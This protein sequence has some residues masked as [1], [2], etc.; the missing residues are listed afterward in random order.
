[1]KRCELKLEEINRLETT[2]VAPSE[3]LN[4]MLEL[5]GTAPLK[6]G[7]KLAEL[8]RRPQIE[9]KDLEQF[10]K[11]RPALSDDVIEKVEI[12]IKYK[13]YIQKQLAAI[14]EMKRLEE[15]I[16]PKDFDY[17]SISGLRKEAVEKLSKIRPESVG[18][19]SRISGVSPADI[20]VLL[21]WLD[22]MEKS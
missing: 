1:L 16:I 12:E 21:I 22:R 8:L 4:E 20:S 2:T 15:K 13:G 19:A 3:Q 9:Y 11:N 18:Q 14:K 17:K 7:A 5:K 6:T 10:D